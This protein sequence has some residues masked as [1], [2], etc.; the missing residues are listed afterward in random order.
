MWDTNDFKTSDGMLRIQVTSQSF[1][2]DI[3]VSNF[4]AD[5]LAAMMKITMLHWIILTANVE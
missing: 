1:M 3:W 2:P 5:P 4:E